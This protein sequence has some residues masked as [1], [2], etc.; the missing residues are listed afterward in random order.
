MNQSLFKTN[1][2]KALFFSW[3]ST[4]LCSATDKV[5]L[6]AIDDTTQ[7]CTMLFQAE[8]KAI[9]VSKYQG[10]DTLPFG[11]LHDESDKPIAAS[12]LYVV[13]DKNKQTKLIVKDT[14]TKKTLLL[15]SL[16][17]PRKNFLGI[18]YNDGP[19]AQWE[20]KDELDKDKVAYEVFF[21]SE[22]TKLAKQLE[23]ILKK[24]YP[25]LKNVP[26]ES[27]STDDPSGKSSNLQCYFFV[28]AVVMV[29]VVGGVGGY[30]IVQRKKATL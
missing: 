20:N 18:Y 10:K 11:P 9:F 15:Q 26:E 4:T 25:K 5:S 8:L 6:P 16:H 27:N 24:D 1:L 22:D 3:L 30:M 23:A 2:I 13:E 17:H 7:G 29:V 12:T 19:S 14:K 28:G 21:K